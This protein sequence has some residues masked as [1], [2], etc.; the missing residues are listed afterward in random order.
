MKCTKSGLSCF[1]IATFVSCISYLV[2][3]PWIWRQHV[4]IWYLPIHSEYFPVELIEQRW[5]S[6]S[7][8]SFHPWKKTC[9]RNSQEKNVI[10]FRW[11]TKE[12]NRK[13]NECYQVWDRVVYPIWFSPLF[14]CYIDSQSIDS[15]K[16]YGRVFLCFVLHANHMHSNDRDKDNETKKGQ[17]IKMP[18]TQA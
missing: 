11:M 2:A 4:P 3:I 5:S 15:N 13:Q 10:F 6:S 14:F 17:I 16:M 18:D 12:P 1:F 9:S 8:F 7:S